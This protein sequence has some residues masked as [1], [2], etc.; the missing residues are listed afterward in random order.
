MK[1]LV[2]AVLLFLVCQLFLAPARPAASQ[3][4][5]WQ[6]GS[7]MGEVNIWVA[8]DSMETRIVGSVLL[9]I[10]S[11]MNYSTKNAQLYCF[12]NDVAGNGT[13]GARFPTEKIQATI[14]TLRGGPGC[15]GVQKEYTIAPPVN[16]NWSWNYFGGCLFGSCGFGGSSLP[17]GYSPLSA[18]FSI[19]FK[20]E[21]GSES[22]YPISKFHG[23]GA[24]S[25]I[26]NI[27]IRP[28]L[29]FTDWPDLDFTISFHNISSASGTCNMK[30]FP[31]HFDSNGIIAN[32]VTAKYLSIVA[33]CEWRMT[34]I[35]PNNNLP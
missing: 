35:D 31:R 8:S 1:R 2:I 34:Y 15:T 20:P 26:N 5:P 16:A 18:G 19:P 4:V 14:F 29:N 9:D 10:H 30:T 6:P 23:S 12:V 13:C 32:Y 17:G 7:Y 22:L 11:Q 24:C 21:F 25:A 33:N 27:L 3:T 28:D